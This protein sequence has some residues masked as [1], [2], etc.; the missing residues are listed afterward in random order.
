MG[1]LLVCSEFVS[2][3]V[4]FFA[5]T[6]FPHLILSECTPPVNESLSAEI[7]AD[8]SLSRWLSLGLEYSDDLVLRKNG[9]DPISICGTRTLPNQRTE[10]SF[11]FECTNIWVD[12]F[13]LG[14]ESCKRSSC[15]INFLLENA[16]HS[17]SGVYL[18]ESNASRCIVLMISITVQETKPVCTSSYP[19]DS[20]LFRMTCKWKPLH[21]NEKV[22]F[23]P[24]DLTWY[25]YEDD[26]LGHKLN[27]FILLD[28]AFCNGKLPDTC[29]VM[30]FGFEKKCQFSTRLQVAKFTGSKQQCVSFN[31][32]SSSRN[33]PSIWMYDGNSIPPLLDITGQTIQS[34]STSRGCNDN[35][36]IIIWGEE[37]FAELTIYGI[38]KLVMNPNTQFS[39]EF[40]LEKFDNHEVA[41]NYEQCSSD[42]FIN[43]LAFPFA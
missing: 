21:K 15:N 1:E 5:L 3:V 4:I 30:Q 29:T 10:V 25:Q 14:F 27:K 42:S 36:I 32:S 35:E 43:I 31:F 39:L 16:L 6:C 40:S 19:K 8:V 7:G 33:D 37:N 24:G 9:E 23:S 26:N 17:D 34:R 18:I 20:E 22:W 12:K 2:S 13:H 41:E 28:D 11:T 38:G